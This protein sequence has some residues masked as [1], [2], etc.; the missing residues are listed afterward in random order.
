MKPHKS[1]I[2][3]YVVIFS[4]LLV[5][6]FFVM[7]IAGA[8]PPSFLEPVSGG[9]QK[10][11]TWIT[12]S[13]AYLGAIIGA[14]GAVIIMFKTINEGRK[15]K[16]ESRRYADYLYI[17]DRI[18]SMMEAKDSSPNS[19]FLDFMQKFTHSEIKRPNLEEV[20][21]YRSKF[22][23][24]Y[25]SVRRAFDQTIIP[26]QSEKIS[27]FMNCVRDLLNWQSAFYEYVDLIFDEHY[28]SID[29]VEA[30]KQKTAFFDELYKS[31]VNYVL[32]FRYIKDSETFNPIEYSFSD[33]F[34]EVKYVNN[35]RELTKKN[36]KAETE[37]IHVHGSLIRR[38]R[39]QLS[40][41]EEAISNAHSELMNSM[42]QQ[43]G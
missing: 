11:Q 15:E 12:F 3:P 25:S 28:M 18:E 9:T 34:N 33:S 39:E 21:S 43:I 19:R 20:V 31:I 24:L 38:Y 13:G 10:E 1:T 23:V 5:V 17:R 2:L 4:I 30:N 7:I 6:P 27:S 36:E 40:K 32:D 41:I 16:I 26:N 35:G 22:Q 42:K 8:Q 29:Y 14:V 37:F